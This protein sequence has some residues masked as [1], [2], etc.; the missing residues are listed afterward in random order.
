[1]AADPDWL[2]G[3]LESLTG[4]RLRLFAIRPA[5]RPRAIV[6]INHGMAEHA[7]RYERFGRFLAGR[8]YGVVAHD[9]R[10]HGR[11]IAPD[12]P[13]GVFGKGDAW[14]KVLADVGIV[15]AH[16][17]GLFP[18]APVV[19]FGHSMGAIVAL[20]Y[21]LRHP[22]TVDAAA[23]WNTSFETPAL[24]HL[25]VALLRAERLFKG[26]DVPSPIAASLTFGAWNKAFAPNR[27]EFDWLSHDEAEVD[28][29]IADPLCGFPVAVGTWLS[30][31][32]GIR[33]A[34]VMAHLRALPGAMPFHLCGGAEDPSSLGG[35]AIV[36]LGERLRAAGLD[37][38]EVTV[39]PGTRHEGLNETN[40]DAIMQDF[41]RWL[42]ARFA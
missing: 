40:R 33:Y 23:I 22:D 26:S 32:E 9:H 31:I 5:G 42:D 14:P 20:N 1:M 3:E 10:G 7:A 24:L 6:Q 4:A 15:N 16:A 13:L 39:H 18:D 38:V 41:A 30:V 27:T 17:R 21:C 36:R 35:E 34:G 29:Y 28:S 37:D 2:E 25:L 8:G 12:A 19:C 11:T